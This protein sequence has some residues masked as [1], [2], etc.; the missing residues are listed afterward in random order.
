MKSPVCVR[1]KRDLMGASSGDIIK[2]PRQVANRLFQYDA[3]EILCR[4]TKE[5][6]KRKML[7]MRATSPEATMHAAWN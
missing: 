5:D 2:I 3:V 6:I 4:D 7:H 1:L